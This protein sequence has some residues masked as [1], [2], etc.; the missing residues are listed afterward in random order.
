LSSMLTAMVVELKAAGGRVEDSRRQRRMAMWLLLLGGE[1]GR[2]CSHQR[3]GNINIVKLKH[4]EY[5]LTA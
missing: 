5:F 4:V 2:E 1:G 3:A